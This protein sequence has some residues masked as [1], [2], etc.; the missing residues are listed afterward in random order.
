MF[1][2][3]V[4]WAMVLRIAST[5]T[6]PLDVAIWETAPTITCASSYYGCQLVSI[7]G[8]LVN[9]QLSFSG[10]ERWSATAATGSF[11][12]AVSN[13]LV[14]S[15]VSFANFSASSDLVAVGK[16][17]VGSTVMIVDT[18]A[19]ATRSATGAMVSA[20]TWDRSV[21]TVRN[22]S[23]RS[24][25]TAGCGVTAIV[26]DFGS[27]L[28]TTTMTIINSI[29]SA[30]APS[31]CNYDAQP[32]AVILKMIVIPHSLSLRDNRFTASAT[33]SAII[34]YPTN[35][36]PDGQVDPLFWNSSVISC[37]S[38]Y[39]TCYALYV[40]SAM[41]GQLIHITENPW[42]CSGPSS[43]CYVI[44]VGGN[45]QATTI[46]MS[47]VALASGFFACGG[48][49]FVDS[50]LTI[51]NSTLFHTAS[52]NVRI[53]DLRAAS[54]W[55]RSRVAIQ[56]STLTAFSPSA[57]PAGGVTLLHFGSVTSPGGLVTVADNVM[58]ARSV[59][60]CN[61]AGY[62]FARAIAF[63]QLDGSKLRGFNNTINVTS[64]S[65]TSVVEIGDLTGVLTGWL[66]TGCAVRCISISGPC[67][68]LS[69]TSAMN[70][71]T[72]TLSDVRFTAQTPP[73]SV[74]ALLSLRAITNSLLS[75]VGGSDM[76]IDGAVFLVASRLVNSSVA[77]DS[78]SFTAR[79]ATSVRFVTI[80]AEFAN[81]S[82]RVVPASVL[83]TASSACSAPS[84][85]A[86]F[87]LPAA[88]LSA[89]AIIGGGRLTLN[90]SATT[91]Q[92]VAPTHPIVGIFSAPIAL[93]N[94]SRL[95]WANSKMSLAPIPNI[96][97]NPD[98]VLIPVASLANS[99]VRLDRLEVRFETSPLTW[100]GVLAVKG[101]VE[102]SK[103]DVSAV[104]GFL[105]I[106][107]S[108]DSTIAEPMSQSAAVNLVRFEGALENS[109][110]TMQNVILADETAC[111][112]PIR[113]LQFRATVSGSN[114]SVIGCRW[115]IGNSIDVSNAAAPA[116]PGDSS[117]GPPALISG[118]RLEAGT[119]VAIRDS[120][121]SLVLPQPAQ[122]G[123]VD[124]SPDVSVIRFEELTDARSSLELL[125][126]TLAF[127][128]SEKLC[129]SATPG[130]AAAS[131]YIFGVSVG[132]VGAGARIH[133][134]RV[135]LRGQVTGASQSMTAVSV[136]DCQ[137]C[138]ISLYSVVVRLD[139]NA[140]A[141]GSAFP[142][143]KLR[144]VAVANP[145][146]GYLQGV[147]TVLDAAGITAAS[148]TAFFVSG[149]SAAGNRLS[150][151][152]ADCNSTSAQ[153]TS[154]PGAVMPLWDASASQPE[155]LT[156]RC[157]R[158]D[159]A[160]VSTASFPAVLGAGAPTVLG[161]GVCDREIDCNPAFTVGVSGVS[162]LNC[163]CECEPVP[164]ARRGYV[165]YDERCNRYERVATATR[166][167]SAS[168]SQWKRTTSRT[169]TESLPAPDPTDTS[170]D[171]TSGT[172]TATTT[173]VPVASSPQTTTTSEAATTPQRPV[174]ATTVSPP[175]PSP[176]TPAP[177]RRARTYT[178]SRSMTRKRAKLRI[179][180]R[181]KSATLALIVQETF[182]PAPRSLAQSLEAVMPAAL[183]EAVAS[184]S[185]A[186]VAAAGAISPAAANKGA[187][188]A[189]VLSILDCAFDPDN[190]LDP[191][192]LEAMFPLSIGKS[193]YRRV[194]GPLLMQSCF[195][196]LSTILVCILSMAGRLKRLRRVYGAFHGVAMGL[197]LPTL[198]GYTTLV[199][200][201][202]ET[203]E[204]LF[205]GAVG[206][207]AIC[208]SLGIPLYFT[209]KHARGSPIMYAGGDAVHGAV[210]KIRWPRPSTAAFGFYFVVQPLKDS[211]SIP[212]L[213]AYFEDISAAIAIAIVANSKP[214][215][216][217]ACIWL[218]VSVTTLTAAHMVYVF[219][220]RPY[221]DRVDSICCY[222]VAS[223]Q[224]LLAVL[225]VVSIYRPRALQFVGVT[226]LTLS[227]TFFMQLA[228]SLMFTAYEHAAKL[229][230][231]LHPAGRKV[232]NECS[233]PATPHPLTD[234][235]EK[236]LLA[237][238]SLSQTSASSSK[239]ILPGLPNSE[240][241]PNCAQPTQSGLDSP[242]PS[243][244]PLRLSPLPAR[245]AWARSLGPTNPFTVALQS[246]EA[247][248]LLVHEVMFGGGLP[249]ASK[250]P[251][252]ASA[253]DLM[254]R[255][256][257][258]DGHVM[259]PESTMRSGSQVL[260]PV[261]PC[262]QP[263][264]PPQPQKV[265]PLLLFDD[266]L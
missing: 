30:S 144:G 222:V 65:W 75:V 241:S 199:V 80:A 61:W 25:S 142:G 134:E 226:S 259:W 162:P 264:E 109:T 130:G 103:V 111:G 97:V 122:S 89:V 120:T 156:I 184:T 55:T 73:G 159:D 83:L 123:S 176:L 23:L 209:L 29:L 106:S 3:A 102:G 138:N 196:L 52:A 198:S 215:A 249:D 262:K 185:S 251:L 139:R 231:R 16:S 119:V 56:G 1:V 38:T 72:V 191:P 78:G 86:F 112:R 177:L 17:V 76:V 115:M 41:E 166:H 224:C 160:V 163:A 45:V 210:E 67:Y 182:A 77:L 229:W 70:D 81:A 39:Y 146:S 245:A 235:D 232:A 193:A 181:T 208:I 100:V 135:T 212:V 244:T 66:T 129:G 190:D 113:P 234:I 28:S 88:T 42:T 237:N 118:A 174:P 49:Q 20:G 155:A 31:A 21:L 145:M 201:H 93:A 217:G 214:P 22:A 33:G 204:R 220:V 178:L 34:L 238:A 94:D 2:R 51:R 99:T 140:S 26:F 6:F 243:E 59:A 141:T 117:K 170:T 9:Q 227:L 175:S 98:L 71:A 179:V 228:A 194:V 137:Q 195:L 5:V 187:N 143:L 133:A 255:Q 250:G 136:G 164:P 40:Q 37:F 116:A 188:M 105:S 167:I 158:V 127:N 213:L 149:S 256:R 219:V 79:G 239:E 121:I 46:S 173:E 48:T 58:S 124:L 258:G 223:L 54:N 18:N 132:S 32:S 233:T 82:L 101:A 107:P 169:T 154:Q 230:A 4:G 261:P 85:V 7:A 202:A 110:V 35:A 263:L 157:N 60:G 247:P 63:T 197:L 150:V 205:F 168:V 92:H 62:N 148:A 266:D 84:S 114:V 221:L 189:N 125:R 15:S 253:F 47:D 203:F 211:R 236:S 27:V 95:D 36:A 257:F 104:T 8:D 207:V 192:P 248:L 69:V 64:S 200:C 153:T 11:V 183:G 90:A 165:R 131:S 14:N 43:G 108:S 206:V 265:A 50:S 12:L 171:T 242:M 10:Q 151:L 180:R 216:A 246:P 126:S 96:A 44:G 240:S 186:S 147:A 91:C 225:T 254:M 252:V 152:L 53:V 57:C 172:T 24:I 161:C 19:V 74:A 128:F 218:A 13:D 87:Y 260:A 68:L